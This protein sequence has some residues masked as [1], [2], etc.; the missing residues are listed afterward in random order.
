VRGHP[1][2]ES[3]SFPSVTF[4]QHQQRLVW[5]SPAERNCA[6]SPHH[7]ERTA[8][9]ELPLKEPPP[10]KEDEIAQSPFDPFPAA[11]CYPN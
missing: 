11:P 1:G 7:T 10:K 2:F 4:S 9:V 3:S 6:T 5:G 8:V